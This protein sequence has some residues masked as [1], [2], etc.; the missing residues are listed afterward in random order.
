LQGS[1]IE[2]R[3]A[4]DSVVASGRLGETPLEGTTALYWTEVAL[5]APAHN[6]VATWSARFAGSEFA[7]LHNESSAFLSFASV[8]P[9]EHT[10]TVR[11]IDEET[12]QPIE[13][14]HIRLGV[15]RGVTRASGAAELSVPK[16]TYDIKVW[17]V[18]YE[19]SLMAVEVVDDVMVQ[20]HGTA[21]PDDNPAARFWS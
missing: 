16:G 15:F 11:L 14:A 1:A 9:P 13:N 19:A 21:V 6:V 4:A 10:L 8:R 3:D 2:I 18:S 17:H 12:Q 20:L 7:L 5:I